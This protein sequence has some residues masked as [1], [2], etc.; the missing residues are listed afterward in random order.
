MRWLFCLH[1]CVYPQA[2]R[3]IVADRYG[4]PVENAIIAS[5]SRVVRTSATGSFLFDDKR[6]PLLVFHPKFQPVVV[7]S[8]SKVIVLDPLATPRTLE[9]CAEPRISVDVYAVQ[10][11]DSLSVQ[12]YADGERFSQT[13]YGSGDLKV[14][15]THRDGD[16]VEVSF[17][18]N[19]KLQV[20]KTKTASGLLIRGI[21]SAYKP[22]SDIGAGNESVHTLWIG[23]LGRS[24]LFAYSPDERQIDALLSSLC[25]L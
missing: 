7:P 6:S 19:S 5:P 24:S 8:D 12:A 9:S 25:A 4:K 11:P 13:H 15:V 23:S 3:G 2:V 16:Y 14:I 17:T 18:A 22:P 20:W 21:S 10:R 1:L